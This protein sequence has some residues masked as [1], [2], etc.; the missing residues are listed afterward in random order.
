[1]EILEAHSFSIICNYFM[2]INERE[3]EALHLTTSDRIRCFL[4]PHKPDFV[5]V[6]RVVNINEGPKLFRL[7]TVQLYIGSSPKLD[8]H[9]FPIVPYTSLQLL[10]SACLAAPSSAFAGLYSTSFLSEVSNSVSWNSGSGYSPIR[11][12]HS[13]RDQSSR[14]LLAL[15]HVKGSLC[16]NRKVCHPSCVCFPLLVLLNGLTYANY[17]LSSIDFKFLR[18]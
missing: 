4:P 10:S 7:P 11:A 5:K 1:M 17:S 12:F 18:T 9:W 3:S 13:I 8:S 15:A 16:S 2:D 6:R 14:G